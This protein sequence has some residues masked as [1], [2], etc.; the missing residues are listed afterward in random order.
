MNKK[1][2][3]FRIEDCDEVVLE[4]NHTDLG[5]IIEY[6]NVKKLTLKNNTSGFTKK[7]SI[8]SRIIKYFRGK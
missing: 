2:A 8:F 4:N 7:D 5:E 6:K 1:N 3:M